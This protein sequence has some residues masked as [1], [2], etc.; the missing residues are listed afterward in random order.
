[1]RRFIVL[2]TV[3]ATIIAGQVLFADGQP[4][5]TADFFVI[6]A[7]ECPQHITLIVWDDTVPD[8]ELDCTIITPPDHGSVSLE[9]P[10]TAPLNSCKIIYTST[11][12]FAG[13]GSRVGLSRWYPRC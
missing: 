8:D 13:P 11:N 5:Q 12:G 2:M 10:S 3:I 9:Y 1:M 4:P 7:T 6:S